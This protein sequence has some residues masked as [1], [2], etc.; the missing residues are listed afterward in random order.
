MTRLQRHM[1]STR[2]IDPGELRRQLDQIVAAGAPGAAAWTQ[3]ETGAQQAASGVANLRTGQPMQP[4]LHFR[5]GS[6]TKSFVA[7]VVL[8][9]AADGRLS[10]QDTVERWLPRIL[11]YGDQ[12]TIRRLLNH[13]SGVPDYVPTVY[14]TLYG[15][16]S[17]RSRAWTP[18][19]LVALV[20]GQPLRFPP[21]TSW[22]YANTGYILLGLIVEAAT[23]RTLAQE[24]A[25]RIL[26]PLG[27]RGTR[28]PVNSPGIP[29]PRSRGYSLPQDPKGDVLGGPLLDLTAENPSWAGAAGALVSDLE[30]LTR[31]FRTLLGG[32]LL[33]PELLAEMLTTVPF[34]PGAVPLPLLDRY[35]LGL[36]EVDTPAGHLVGHPG[37]IPGFLSIVL[38]TP[39]GG[40]QLA[41]MINALY[42][43][44][45]VYG[46]F[47]QAFRE[48]GMRLLVPVPPS[49]TGRARRAAQDST[50][51]GTS[52]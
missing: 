46:A 24:L 19:E 6:I 48:L 10:L 8:Q 51:N 30:D 14:Q 23:G 15:S 16:R 25:R 21:G 9:L 49:A 31:F 41:L 27:L 39:D 17:G 12:L 52:G 2:R 50:S 29:M 18:R 3:D 38:S 44:D 13:T 33:P 47:I 32:R 34:P 42:A 43:P 1:S 20:A 28:F 37:G 35:G 26:E 22:S 7:T 11:P 45:P 40:R 36:T 5:A 4:D